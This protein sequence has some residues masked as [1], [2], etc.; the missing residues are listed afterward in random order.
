MVYNGVWGFH[1]T[2]LGTIMTRGGDACHREDFSSSTGQGMIWDSLRDSSIWG[3]SS[4]MVS[5]ML[6][7]ASHEVWNCTRPWGI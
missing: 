6:P 1:G 7:G 5:T 2:S 3:L 4:Q